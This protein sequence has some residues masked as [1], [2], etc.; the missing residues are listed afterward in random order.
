M[1]CS[2]QYAAAD[3]PDFDCASN[4][5]AHSDGALFAHFP[6]KTPSQ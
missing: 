4:I 1:P 6:I 3:L 2:L 5:A